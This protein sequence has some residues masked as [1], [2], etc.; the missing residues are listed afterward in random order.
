MIGRSVIWASLLVVLAGCG[1]ASGAQSTYEVVVA[2]MRCEQSGT[3][4]MECMY[5][6]G[7]DLRFRIAGVGETEA[8]IYFERSLKDGDFYASFGV[9]HGCVTIWPGHGDR[10]GPRD[11]S[12][13]QVDLAFVSPQ[14]GK[15]YR[16]WQDCLDANRRM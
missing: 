14:N 7:R 9:Q 1:Q 11:L 6:V 13:A 10:R 4:S 8:G 12:A 3:G 2:G 16:G 15:V 5:S